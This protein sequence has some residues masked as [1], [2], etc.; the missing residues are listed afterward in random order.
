M[1]GSPVLWV[2]VVLIFSACTSESATTTSDDVLLPPVTNQAQEERG[3]LASIR[4]IE[5][6]LTDGLVTLEVSWAVSITPVKPYLPSLPNLALPAS[7]P[8]H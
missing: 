3:Y 2:L 5:E 8:V 1:R 7:S 4:S 6:S